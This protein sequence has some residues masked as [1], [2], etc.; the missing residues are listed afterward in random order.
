MGRNWTFRNGSSRFLTLCVSADDFRAVTKRCMSC[1]LEADAGA[2]LWRM[3][4]AGYGQGRPR[5]RGGHPT[6]SGQERRVV[7]VFFRVALYAY[8]SIKA[9]S[10][11][12]LSGVTP[13]T[14]R[15]MGGEGREHGYAIG[16]AV[17]TVLLPHLPQLLRQS[18]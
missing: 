10:R 15:N 12:R 6:E 8:S 11:A 13:Q 2:V 5:Y 3:T 7:G 4:A 9:P 17:T 1:T 18:P 14:N 16:M